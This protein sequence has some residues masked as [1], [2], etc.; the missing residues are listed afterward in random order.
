V[1]WAFRLYQRAWRFA[2]IT[3]VVD[4]GGAVAVASVL[5]FV[6]VRLFVDPLASA[7]L[8]GTH[9]LLLMLSVSIG[10][11]SFRV[12]AHLKASSRAQGR[13]V[14]VYGAGERGVMAVNEIQRLDTLRMVPVGFI[15][16]DPIKQRRRIGGLP[17]LGAVTVLDRII[18]EHR[19]EGV[20]VASTTITPER[21]D[22]AMR[23]CSVC[24]VALFRFNVGVE[25]LRREV[26]VQPIGLPA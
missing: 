14:L 19:I 18:S 11:S 4:A 23:T 16:D 21:L 13:R 20:I 10:R 2:G 6:L 3:D 25:S 15:D 17:V 1:F 26:V 22:M 24:E 12:L 8:F 9:M 5:G 7:T